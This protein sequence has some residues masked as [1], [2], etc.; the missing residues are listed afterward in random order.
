MTTEAAEN[1]ESEPLF[2]ETELLFFPEKCVLILL[3]RLKVQSGMRTFLIIES[4]VFVDLLSQLSFGAVII[5]VKLLLLEHS[6]EGFH[7]GVVVRCSR[8]GKRLYN[9]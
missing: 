6:K 8:I 7:H 1:L 2:P 3:W 4:N 5:A 9:L